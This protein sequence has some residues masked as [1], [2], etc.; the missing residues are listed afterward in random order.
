[1]NEQHIPNPP[2]PQVGDRLSDWINKPN[3]NIIQE[4][5]TLEGSWEGREIHDIGV[6][7]DI[8]TGINIQFSDTECFHARVEINESLFEGTIIMIMLS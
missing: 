1:M 4:F 7:N 8:I 6:D 2:I 3:V 5:Y